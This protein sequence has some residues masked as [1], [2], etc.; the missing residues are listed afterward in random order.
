MRMS[1]SIYSSLCLW[2]QTNFR[3]RLVSLLCDECFLLFIQ[4]MTIAFNIKVL[5][6]IPVACRGRGGLWWLKP[7]H[8]PKSLIKSTNGC[9]DRWHYSSLGTAKYLWFILVTQVTPPKKNTGQSWAHQCFQL[10]PFNDTCI[11]DHRQLFEFCD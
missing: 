4:I 2:G 6:N 9:N 10:L 11:F 7:L 5:C 8:I 1:S 3:N